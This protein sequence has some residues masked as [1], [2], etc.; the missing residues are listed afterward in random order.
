MHRIVSLRCAVP[1]EVDK[2]TV[3]VTPGAR[4]PDTIS[5]QTIAGP[6]SSGTFT[7]DGVT[8]GAILTNTAEKKEGNKLYA[9]KRIP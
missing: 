9:V 6:P 4:V 3:A 2:V 1:S 8:G 5:V 7:S